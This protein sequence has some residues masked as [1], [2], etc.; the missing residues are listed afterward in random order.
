MQLQNSSATIIN[1]TATYR[2]EDP[3]TVLR[4]LQPSDVLN[5]YG[6]PKTLLSRSAKVD[7][8]EKFNVSVGVVY[9][10]PG[11]F[12]P[13]ATD[14]CRKGCLGHTSGHMH[15]P[16]PTK[17]RDQ[18]SALYVE[19]N[20][21][22][23][24]Q[25]KD[26]IARHLARCKKKQLTPAIRLN[27][28]SDISWERRHR[29]I[30]DEF[31]TVQFYDYTKVR[32]RM[33]QYLASG[34]KCDNSWPSNYHLTFSGSGSQPDVA[35]RILHAGGNVA[36]VFWPEL[37][38]RWWDYPV[39]DGDTHDARFVDP[40]GAIVGLRAKGIARVDTASFVVRACPSCDPKSS[41]LQLIEREE[42]SHR[43]LEHRCSVCGYCVQ[44]K[45]KLP[46]LRKANACSQAT[47]PT[48]DRLQLRLAM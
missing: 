41:E 21:V 9:L 40:A 14:A 22:F 13:S 47:P 31:P 29:D 18:R 48:S 6:P 30:F 15:M 2:T 12:C 7:K 1:G 20:E 24:Q 28:T 19:Q 45:W 35:K 36:V 46:E 3:K 34:T 27:G 23:C 44:S 37:P 4:D 25:L 32:V 5:Q 43:M 8:C 26:E 39:I 33:S 17:A 10:T 38:S 16:G 11:Y 42:D